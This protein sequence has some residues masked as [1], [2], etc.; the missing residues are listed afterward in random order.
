MS[1]NVEVE[2]IKINPTVSRLDERLSVDIDYTIDT[3]IANTRW[4]LKVEKENRH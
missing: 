4:T 3:I 2:E 1:V